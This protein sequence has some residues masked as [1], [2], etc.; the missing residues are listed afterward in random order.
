MKEERDKLAKKRDTTE[1]CIHILTTS[2]GYVMFDDTY[3]HKLLVLCV[4]NSGA[5]AKPPFPPSQACRFE[6]DPTWVVIC[7]QELIKSG[8]L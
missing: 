1:R 8:V 4:V 7:S 6:H 3:R 2:P 5:S